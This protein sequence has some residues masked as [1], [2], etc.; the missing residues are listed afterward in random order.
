MSEEKKEETYTKK[1]ARAMMIASI[2]MTGFFVGMVYHGMSKA[3]KE[4]DGIAQTVLAPA[5]TEVRGQQTKPGDLEIRIEDLDKDGQ[6][7]TIIK[8][9]GQE[10]LMRIDAEGKTQLLKYRIEKKPS[11]Y[12]PETTKIITEQD[13]GYQIQK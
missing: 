10:Y 1:D 9:Q 3:I 8:V 11:A 12:V 7:E 6:R 13:Q 4:Y 2:A 5:V